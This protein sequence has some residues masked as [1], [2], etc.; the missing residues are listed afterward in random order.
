[1]IIDSARRMMPE[2]E[3][4]AIAAMNFLIQVEPG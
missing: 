4:A 1:V 3:S 2:T